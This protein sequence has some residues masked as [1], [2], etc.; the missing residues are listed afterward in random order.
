MDRSAEADAEGI[1]MGIDEF[2]G[3]AVDDGFK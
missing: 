3:P 2:M 1:D